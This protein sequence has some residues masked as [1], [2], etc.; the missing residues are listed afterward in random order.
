[1][2]V[3]VFLARM[4][5]MHNAH[6]WM[7]EKAC[8]ENDM[9]LIVLGSSN[10]QET[11]RNPFS[12]SERVTYLYRHISKNFSEEDVSKIKVMELP[13]WGKEN[14]VMELDK[15]G[16]YLYYNIVA[17]IRQ[18]HFSIYYSDDLDFIKLWF[19]HSPFIQKRVSIIYVERQKVFNALSAT[20]IRK[21]FENDDFDCIEQFCPEVI[22]KNYEGIRERYLEI[23]KN[24]KA[25]YKMLD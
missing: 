21:A 12:H 22:I 20:K 19:K 13:D 2:K 25:D 7:I 14:G 15:W 6:L 16:E 18:K 1:M 8:E 9:V 17:K 23:F 3:G 24:P 4:Q 10:K 5:P 11:L